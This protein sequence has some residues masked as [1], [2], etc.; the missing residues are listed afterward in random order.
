VDFCEFQDRQ[1]CIVRTCLKKEEMGGRIFAIPFYS[2]K[3]LKESGVKIKIR[4]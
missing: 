2:Y 4:N 3:D 1:I